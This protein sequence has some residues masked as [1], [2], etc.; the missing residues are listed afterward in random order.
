MRLSYS[1]VRPSV[2]P[3]LCPSAHPNVGDAFFKNNKNQ[4]FSTI[5]TQGRPWKGQSISLDASPHVYKM[6]SL[7]VGRSACQSFM[8]FNEIDLFQQIKARGSQSYYV[9]NHTIMQAFHRSWGRIVGVVGLVLHKKNWLQNWL[10][11]DRRTDRLMD[12]P[13]TPLIEMGGPI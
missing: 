6:V 9:M 8:K 5:E 13:T 3:S 2:H 4:C 7:S 10:R 1:S 11:T 12:Q